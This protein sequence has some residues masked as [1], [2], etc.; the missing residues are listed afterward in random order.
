Q[1][2]KSFR[3]AGAVGPAMGERATAGLDQKRIG[4]A[5]VAAIKLDDL[6][7]PGK[8]AGQANARHRRFGSAVDHS[9]FFDRR[10][11]LANQL[12]HFEFERIWN[13][14]TQSVRGRVAHGIDN[15]FWRVTKN[16][17]SPAADVIDVFL[18][19]DVPNF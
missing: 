16:R 19:V 8:S 17:R 4:M 10:H 13:S 12:G 6:V 7:E 9:D 2:G 3:N 5:M 18:S 15:Y 1:L 14:K 11:P